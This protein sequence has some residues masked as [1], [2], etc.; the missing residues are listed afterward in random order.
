MY[1]GEG[2]WCDSEELPLQAGTIWWQ[3]IPVK[4]RNRSDCE[5]FWQASV[6]VGF[7]RRLACS[8]LSNLYVSLL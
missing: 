3:A 6:I 7:I 2:T 5:I 1:Q 4:L 8:F